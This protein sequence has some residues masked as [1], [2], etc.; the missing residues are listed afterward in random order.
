MDDREQHDRYYRILAVVYVNNTNLNEKLLREGYAEIMYNPP[1][2]FNP[3]EWKADYPSIFGTF[4]GIIKRFYECS[5]G[6]HS[7]M[8]RN[9][10]A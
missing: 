1:S 8:P 5:Q 9:R 2:E 6:F 7:F 3:Y 4:K 10:R